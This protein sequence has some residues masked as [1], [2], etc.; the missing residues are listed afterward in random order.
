MRRKMSVAG[1]QGTANSTVAVVLASRSPVLTAVKACVRA[2]GSQSSKQ[3]LE[4]K[5]D[6]LFSCGAG[7]DSTVD[8]GL[9]VAK[10]AIGCL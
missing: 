1:P 6:M 10:H 2:E 5:E 7:L 9:D 4:H 8:Q 3:S